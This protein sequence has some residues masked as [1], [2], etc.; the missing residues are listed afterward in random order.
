MYSYISYIYFTIKHVPHKNNVYADALSKLKPDIVPNMYSS[1]DLQEVTL[2]D[3]PKSVAVVSTD[4]EEVVDPHTESLDI[5]NDLLVL[6]L[7]SLQ[8]NDPAEDYVYL[9]SIEDLRP[10][11]EAIHNDIKGH[12]GIKNTTSLLYIERHQNGKLRASC[13]YIM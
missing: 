2:S 8:M 4:K 13:C 7:H 12:F 5:L 11:W 1:S 10:H 9:N 3:D 6:D